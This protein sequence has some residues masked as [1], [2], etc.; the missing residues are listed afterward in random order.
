MVGMRRS[1]RTQPQYAVGHVF[2]LRTGR[3][4]SKRTK[5][6]RCSAS[7]FGIIHSFSCQTVDKYKFCAAR[8]NERL[9]LANAQDVQ[10]GW[11][12]ASFVIVNNPQ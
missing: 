4:L 9:Q 5:A 2:I 6:Y 7:A 11:N 12:L 10:P 3:A 8:T 1:S